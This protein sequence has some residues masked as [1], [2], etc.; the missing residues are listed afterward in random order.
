MWAWLGPTRLPRGPLGYRL[1]KPAYAEPVGPTPPP[2]AGLTDGPRSPPAGAVALPLSPFI[3]FSL[4]S[5][6][7]ALPLPF[8]TA[9]PPGGQM[10]M[11]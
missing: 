9:R 11:F 7:S 10:V 4:F 5:L 2:R 3:S 6:G 1:A 8:P